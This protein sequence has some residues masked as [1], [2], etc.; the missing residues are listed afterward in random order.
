MNENPELGVFVP[1]GNLKFLQR[2]PGCAERAFGS[3]AVD[4][5]YG[6]FDRFVSSYCLR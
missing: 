4:V 3:Y 2:I 6:I 5:L 1:L